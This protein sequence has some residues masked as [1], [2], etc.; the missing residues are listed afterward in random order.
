[1]KLSVVLYKA[2]LGEV[3]LIFTERQR[4]CRRFTHWPLLQISAVD[5]RTHFKPTGTFH[6]KNF[7]SCHPP[8][9]ARTNSSQRNFEENI[10]NF[11]TSLKNRGYPAAKVEKHPSEVKFSERKTS[12]WPSPPGNEVENDAELKFNRVSNVFR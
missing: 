7:Y 11:A 5:V 10:R 2:T 1:M 4:H 6:Y 12:P 8:G 3:L 9:V